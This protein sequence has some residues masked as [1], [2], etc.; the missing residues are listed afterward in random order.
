MSLIQDLR[1]RFMSWAFPLSVTGLTGISLRDLDE[2]EFGNRCCRLFRVCE[3]AVNHESA[4][5][6]HDQWRSA[7]VRTAL[8]ARHG[9]GV[10]GITIHSSRP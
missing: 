7:A 1:I 9:L 8:L 10:A 6:V 2:T 5:A 4:P 3:H